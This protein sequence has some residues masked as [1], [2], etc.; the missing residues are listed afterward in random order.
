[1]AG[2]LEKASPSFTKTGFRP[3]CF[4]AIPIVGEGEALKGA[5]PCRDIP[6]PEHRFG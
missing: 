3:P 2:A 1:L 5:I 4:R 6:Q